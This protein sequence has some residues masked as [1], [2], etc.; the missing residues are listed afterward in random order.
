L[1]PLSEMPGYGAECSWNF[2]STTDT[3]VADAEQLCPALASNPHGAYPS[4]CAAF[5][6]LGVRVPF[7]AVSPFSKSTYVSHIVTDHTSILAMIEKRFLGSKSMTNRD[8]DATTPEDLFNFDTSP[9]LNA[10][11]TQAEPPAVDCTP[12]NSSGA[13]GVSLRPILRSR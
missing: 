2:T 11:V 8:K 9:S 12:P 7:I 6:Q 13:F 1:P 4:N 5:N 10:T 3:S